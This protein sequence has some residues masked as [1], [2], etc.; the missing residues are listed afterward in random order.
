LVVIILCWFP[1]VEKIFWFEVFH[2]FNWGEL[3]DFTASAKGGSEI[4]SA[5]LASAKSLRLF[6]SEQVSFGGVI[7][8]F[9]RTFFE[10]NSWCAPPL[11]SGD[12]E[13]GR[14]TRPRGGGVWGGIRAGFGFPFLKR[15]RLQNQNTY[16]EKIVDFC[17]A[18]FVSKERNGSYFY[19]I[20]SSILWQLYHRT[21]SEYEQNKDWRRTTW[22]KK[23]I[24]NTLPLPKLKV[25][26]LLS[27]AFK[28][29]KKSPSR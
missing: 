15:R 1:R 17:Y 13:A 7:L 8:A 25:A 20:K 23:P 28:P 24:S 6:N 9:A 29:S 18:C 19:T 10:R 22:R 14:R 27:Q 21:L 4:D 11:F 2:D 16:I 12:M 3:W 5:I 26:L